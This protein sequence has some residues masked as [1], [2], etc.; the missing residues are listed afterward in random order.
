MIKNYNIEK[1][2]E[3]SNKKNYKSDKELF[4]EVFTPFYF[5]SFC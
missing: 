2:K 5:I 1:I 4:G 3:L